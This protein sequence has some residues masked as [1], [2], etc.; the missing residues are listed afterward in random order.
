[1]ELVNSIQDDFCGVPCDFMENIIN[2]QA[3]TIKRQS[4]EI[5]RLTN[6]CNDCAGCTQWKCDCSNIKIQAYEECIA[7]LDAE[8]ES[9]DKYIREYDDSELQKVYNKGLRDALKALKEMVDE[10]NG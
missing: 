7:Q 8:I 1:M 9:S 3:K 2:S 5:E 4:T 10:D 6:K